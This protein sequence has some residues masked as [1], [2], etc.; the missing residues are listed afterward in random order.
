MDPLDGMEAMGLGFVT[1]S[2][3]RMH[4]RIR[5]LADA[6]G[7]RESIRKRSAAYAHENHSLGEAQ[8]LADR[9]LAAA[10]LLS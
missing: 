4:A 3:E 1:D 5:E 8:R 9:M 6:P 10:G 2:L 7:Q